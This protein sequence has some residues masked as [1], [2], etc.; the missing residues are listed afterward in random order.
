MQSMQSWVLVLTVF[1][2]TPA[3]TTPPGLYETRARCVEAGKAYVT[4]EDELLGVTREARC[5]P[6]PTI[7]LA[8][9]GA[10]KK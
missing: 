4:P 9:P 3:I 1:Y 2:Q 5:I 10:N 8:A 7:V 6:G